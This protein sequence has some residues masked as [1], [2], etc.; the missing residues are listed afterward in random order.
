[1]PGRKERRLVTTPEQPLV[2]EVGCPKCSHINES[3]WTDVLPPGGVEPV[4]CAKCGYMILS[5]SEGDPCRLKAPAVVTAEEGAKKLA[6]SFI[7]CSEQC[8]LCDEAMK[9]A[10]GEF[11]VGWTAAIRDAEMA[12]KAD[13]REEMYY[14]LEE[15]HRLLP[16][17][18]KE[19]T[20]Q[21][22]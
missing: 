6:V 10:C 15:A 3:R 17:A 8:D 13:G 21:S 18:P 19:E 1:V 16:P 20:C 22:K 9:K 2:Y 5:E 4:E 14:E 11:R 12:A 7:G